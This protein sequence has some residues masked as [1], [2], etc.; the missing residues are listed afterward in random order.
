MACCGGVANRDSWANRGR[1]LREQVDCVVSGRALRERWGLPRAGEAGDPGEAEAPSAGSGKSTRKTSCQSA[2][3]WGE[4]KSGIRRGRPTP[5]V[6]PGPRRL[7]RGPHRLRTVELGAAEDLGAGPGRQR[8]TQR[9]DGLG[10]GPDRVP[11]IPPAPPPPHA[12]GFP[13][14]SRAA[15]CRGSRRP[16]TAQVPSLLG[17]RPITERAGARLQ[18]RPNERCS[19][20][21]SAVCSVQCGGISCAAGTNWRRQ[22]RGVRPC[23]PIASTRHPPSSDSTNQRLA[24]P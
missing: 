8:L 20:P 22:L 5:C 9:S 24:H 4:S 13:L 19:R 7:P 3:A 11:P 16:I 10:Q 17:P 12:A 14:G 21:L 15:A 18:R 1:G 6:R 2:G 23:G